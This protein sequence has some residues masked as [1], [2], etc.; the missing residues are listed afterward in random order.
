MN[1]LSNFKRGDTLSLVCVYKSEGEPS[2]VEG[3]EIKSQI[4]KSD[5]T[6]VCN[7]DATI[8]DQEE[9]P[10][11]FILTPDVDTKDF[12][13]ALLYCDIEITEGGAKRSSD[14]FQISVV[15]DITK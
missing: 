14:T 10:G 8:T 7:L 5:R 11:Q 13:I 6:L 12:P 1:T 15:E 3:M 9:N 4:R 2:S